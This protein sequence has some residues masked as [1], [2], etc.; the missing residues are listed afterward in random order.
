MKCVICGNEIEDE[1]GHNPAPVKERGRCCTVCNTTVV[2][3]LRL[4]AMTNGKKKIG[5]LWGT[6]TDGFEGSIQ[7]FEEELKKLGLDK[8]FKIVKEGE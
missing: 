5:I 7:D 1:Y 8:H 3:P 2:I 6:H 4:A